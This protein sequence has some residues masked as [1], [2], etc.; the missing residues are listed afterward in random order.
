MGLTKEATQAVVNASSRETSP[1]GQP[2]ASGEA[3]TPRGGDHHPVGAAAP[4]SPTKASQMSPKLQSPKGT[5]AQSQAKT[6]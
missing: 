1:T 5:G 4:S 2:G 6:L 3:K